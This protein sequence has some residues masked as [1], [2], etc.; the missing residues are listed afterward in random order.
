MKFLRYHNNSNSLYHHYFAIIH[1]NTLSISNILHKLVGNLLPTLKSQIKNST[2]YLIKQL[3]KA[4]AYVNLNMNIIHISDSWINTFE[5]SRNLSDDTN[6]LNAFPLLSNEWQQD[7]EYAFLGYKNKAK[8]DKYFDRD[9]KL[10]W[11]E[12]II[13]PWYDEKENVIGAIIQIENISKT[14]ELEQKAEKLE[15]LLNVKSEIAKIGSWEYNVITNKL[16]WCKMTKLIHEVPFDYCPSIEIALNFYKEGYYR[17]LAR[18]RVEKAMKDGDTWHEKFQLTTA[19]GNDIWVQASGKAIFNAGKLVGLIGSFQD[20]SEEVKTQ[21]KTKN[22]EVLLRTLIDNLPLNVFIK[23]LESRKTLVNKAECDYLGM[24]ND[25][26][27][28]KDDFELFHKDSAEISI[29]EDQHIIQ[30]LTPIIRKETINIKKDGTKTMFLTSKIP[31]LNDYLEATGIIGFSLDI[32]HL[33]EKEKELRR[34]VHITSLQNK[35]LINFAHIVSHNLRSHTA[36]FSM[37]LGFLIKEKSDEERE[38]LLNM[39]IS[40]SDNLL[41][42][43]DNLNEVVEINT[44]Q[45]L[46]SKSIHIKTAGAKVKKNLKSL[47]RHKKSKIKNLIDDS[48]YVNG[49]PTY[50]DNILLNV[51][52]NAIKFEDP[53]KECVVEISAKKLKKY[54]VIIIKDNGIGIDLEKNKTKIF[55]MYKTFH[56]QNDSRGIGLFISKNQIEAMKGKFVL[57]SKVDKGTTF[58]IYFKEND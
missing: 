8:T 42:T 20:I 35:K 6:I 58:N 9:N 57:K 15:L 50:V 5:F 34:L 10:N 28:G 31:L 1:N 32:T 43:I 56:Q 7:L 14:I 46:D 19:K 45:N 48:V 22:N 26:I 53:R 52:S 36:N 29:K 40:E 13:Y 49:I 23:D 37:L 18:Q 54:T 16:T 27:I 30:S 12:W 11:L 4:T 39:L 2:D 33:K 47:L 41:E 24:S 38:N 51:I 44:V 17:N 21:Q 55:G 3:P 25:E